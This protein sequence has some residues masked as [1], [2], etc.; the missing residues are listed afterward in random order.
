MKQ[1][2]KEDI[3]YSKFIDALKCNDIKYINTLKYC[4][5]WWSKYNNMAIKDALLN[6]E[7][8]ELIPINIKKLNIK[9]ILLELSKN[10]NLEM[11][12][13]I[14]QYITKDS[15][16]VFT[17]IYFNSTLKFKQICY[18]YNKID[19]DMITK[20]NVKFS[21]ELKTYVKDKKNEEDVKI[22]NKYILDLPE[23]IVLN[24]LRYYYLRFDCNDNLDKTYKRSIKY[25]C[26]YKLL[27][28][29]RIDIWKN[30]PNL[31]DCDNNYYFLHMLIFKSFK[32]WGLYK[33]K[34]IDL[35]IL[36]IIKYLDYDSIK[37]LT[38][39]LSISRNNAE[40]L[41]QFY[42]N[43]I[44]GLLQ[45]YMKMLNSEE[46]KKEVKLYDNNTLWKYMTF[47]FNPVHY[48]EDIQTDIEDVFPDMKIHYEMDGACLW[49]SYDF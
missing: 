10:N 42:D 34:F 5:S 19:I 12:N 35:K 26:T 47:M 4:A 22:I 6:K 31:K 7:T 28:H 29:D 45:N 16:D 9:C 24:I 8:T 15:Y 44:K 21:Y 11:F 33:N 18:L 27:E 14:L 2:T 3:H 46:H 40:E 17:L 43:N 32:C 39:R 1:F 48:C 37:L 23:K 13:H 25:D 38:N 30:I 20:Y 41:I 36:T 49:W